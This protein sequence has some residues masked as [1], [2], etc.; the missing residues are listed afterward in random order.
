MEWLVL[1]LLGAVIGFVVSFA[2]Q[3]TLR[4]PSALVIFVAVLGALGGG[5]IQ[6][7][8]ESITFGRWTFYIAGLGLSVTLLAG[9]LLAY[10]LTNEERRV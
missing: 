6:Q 5:L 1:A 3:Q 4:M 9:A 2:A 7:A 8:T 10:S